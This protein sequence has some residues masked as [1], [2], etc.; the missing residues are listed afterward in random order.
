MPQIKAST[1]NP[2]TLFNLNGLDYAKSIYTIYYDSNLVNSSGV[3]DVNQL[4]V[5]L[6]NKSDNTILE[7]PAKVS[8]W[9]DGTGTA[10]TTLTDLI[11]DL[12]TLV[13]FNSPRVSGNVKEII[14]IS[15]LP[16]PVAGVITLDADTAYE[17]KNPL[18]DLQGSRLVGQLNTG[19]LGSTSETSRITSTGLGVGVPLFT[20]SFTTPIQNITFID[21]DTALSFT[22]DSNAALDWD[23]FNIINCPNIGTVNGCSNWILTNSAFL[24]SKGL[25]FDGSVG[26]I[27]IN[28]SLMVGDGLAGSLIEV[29]PTANI[30][31]RFRSIYSSFVA[32]GST[33]GIDFD[34][35]ATVPVESYILD[36]INFSGGS[37]YLQ[38]VDHTSNKSLFIRCQGIVNTSVNGQLYMRGNATA[39]TISDTTNFF[40]V[41]GT[42]LPSADNSKYEHSNNRLTCKASIERKYFIT[43]TLSFTT[44][45]NNVC[46]FGFLDSKEGGMRPPSITTATANAAGRQEGVTFSCVVQHG[47]D[48]YLEIHARNTTGTNAVTVTDMNFIVIEIK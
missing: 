18:L 35:L 15:D 46:E 9:K 37:T 22:G 44:A 24:N 10:Y 34:N 40:K 23:K 20:S 42:T 14:T 26:T 36:T 29:L 17:F 47:F 30:T 31:R 2:D 25:K 13:G 3:V 45:N 16:E 6:R 8:D 5:G 12:S 28:N 33:V 39:T 27:G 19:I 21:I 48:D 4:R 43:C 32:F 41:A 38:D 11:G 1:I 7:A